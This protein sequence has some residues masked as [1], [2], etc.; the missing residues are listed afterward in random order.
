M[1]IPFVKYQ[2]TGNDFVLIDQ[3]SNNFLSRKDTEI[4]KKICD[5]RFGI[6]GDGLILLELH[7]ELDFEMIYFNSDGNESTMCGNGGRCMVQY[8]RTLGQIESSCDF[9]AIDGSHKATI[10]SKD[11]VELRMNDVTELKKINQHYVLDTGSPHYVIFVENVHNINVKEEGAQIRYSNPYKL[12]GINVNFV[13]RNEDGIFMR[14]YERGVEGETL[15]C[16]TG[17]AAAVLASSEHFDDIRH[18]NLVKVFTPGG[19]LEVKFKR[20]SNGFTDIWLC[21][22]AKKVFEGTIDTSK[23]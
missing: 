21:G 22:P 19:N 18:E 20:S 1:I 4:I 11:W 12:E 5:R 3:R 8:A 17:V 16:G 2:A 6:G 15:S 23:L 9:L 14:T 7:N 10:S 13:E